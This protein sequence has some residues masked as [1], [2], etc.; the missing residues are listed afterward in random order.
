MVTS[1]PK[2]KPLSPLT[3]LQKNDVFLEFAET[4]RKTSFF[5]LYNVSKFG[6]RDAFNNVLQWI[7]ELLIY[8]RSAILEKQLSIIA[9]FAVFLSLKVY[10]VVPLSN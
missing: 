5:I 2:I 4:V 9:S 7:L 10:L 1:N 3:A 8:C 6:I